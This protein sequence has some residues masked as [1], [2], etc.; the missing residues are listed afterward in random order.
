MKK[1]YLLSGSKGHMVTKS[2]L[3][4]Q[5]EAVNFLLV[6]GKYQQAEEQITVMVSNL[7]YLK[8]KIKEYGDSRK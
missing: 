2:M 5:I 4:Q 7:N 1:H 3:S 6:N 8:D